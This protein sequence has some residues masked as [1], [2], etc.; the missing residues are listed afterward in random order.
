M[1]HITLLPLCF[2]VKVYVPQSILLFMES[3][4]SVILLIPSKASTNNWNQATKKQTSDHAY[5]QVK[6]TRNHNC[7]TWV[8]RSQRI[9]AHCFLWSTVASG[10][11]A[12]SALICAKFLSVWW[13]RIYAYCL[14]EWRN[15]KTRNTESDLCVWVCYSILVVCECDKHFKLISVIRVPKSDTLDV[16][17]YSCT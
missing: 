17:W 2:C 9:I 8:F 13:N 14:S 10:T 1:F 3:G 15:A 7:K 4:I 5:I 6:D 12:L 11:F 16:L